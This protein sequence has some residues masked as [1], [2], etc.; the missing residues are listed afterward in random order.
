[1]TEKVINC[2]SA[3]I[4]PSCDKHLVIPSQ[5]NE[6]I[7]IIINKTKTHVVCNYRAILRNILAF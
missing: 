1:M 5:I 3:D 7:I 6:I 2:L 4:V